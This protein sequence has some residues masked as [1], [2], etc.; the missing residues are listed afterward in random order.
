MKFKVGNKYRGL[1]SGNVYEI[2]YECNSRCETCEFRKHN[3][4][5]LLPTYYCVVVIVGKSTAR[6]AK[7]GEKRCVSHTHLGKITKSFG[8]RYAE[9]F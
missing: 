2:I 1:Q 5:Y 3:L 8:E 7:I 9:V 4:N 6:E